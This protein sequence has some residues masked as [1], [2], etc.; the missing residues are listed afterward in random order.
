MYF[1]QSLYV[2]PKLMVSAHVHMYMWLQD[3]IP[4][5]YFHQPYHYAVHMYMH[6]C[7]IHVVIMF[8]LCLWGII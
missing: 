8:T 1:D 2:I 5:R 4:I 6:V 3:S 7:Y